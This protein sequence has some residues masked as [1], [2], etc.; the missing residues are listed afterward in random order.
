M[1]SS[2]V[3]YACKLR[4]V[5]ALTNARPAESAVTWVALVGGWVV[6]AFSTVSE[7]RWRRL[8]TAGGNI[9]C[10]NRLVGASIY[11]RPAIALRAEFFSARPRAHPGTFAVC[12]FAACDFA[13]LSGRLDSIE[14]VLPA[15]PQVHGN[16]I[17]TLRRSLIS[18]LVSGL[19]DGIILVFGMHIAEERLRRPTAG[20]PTQFVWIIART[21]SN[22]K[23]GGHMPPMCP[24][25]RQLANRRLR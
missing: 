18:F 25:N 3:T 9:E 5:A 12:D 19:H 22:N 14:L 24:F 6:M 1:V 11:A 4:A 20:P 13:L 23:V 16:V 17:G 7:H 21:G 15:V 8:L 2:A 10:C